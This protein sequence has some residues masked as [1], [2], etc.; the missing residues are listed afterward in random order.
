MEPRRNYDLFSIISYVLK[1]FPCC[2]CKCE[3][4]I[5]ILCNKEIIGIDDFSESSDIDEHYE[6]GTFAPVKKEYTW[7]HN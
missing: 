1:V 4:V 3:G 5:E 6:H 2:F 7:Y